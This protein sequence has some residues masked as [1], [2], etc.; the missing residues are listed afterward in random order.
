M[1][2]RAGKR[3]DPLTIVPR[4]SILRATVA[5]S[6][7]VAV[8]ERRKAPRVAWSPLRAATPFPQSTA[9]SLVCTENLIPVGARQNTYHRQR[10]EVIA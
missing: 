1:E 9:G 8:A 5:A 7:P 10:A 6:S 4:N 3:I 2:A